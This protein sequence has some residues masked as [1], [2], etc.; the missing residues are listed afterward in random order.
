VEPGKGQ[1]DLGVPGLHCFGDLEHED[2]PLQ[3][4]CGA[5]LARLVEGCAH[6][7]KLEDALVASGV[8]GVLG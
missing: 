2:R 5:V 3:V 6:E 1:T 4:P 8:L 7:E